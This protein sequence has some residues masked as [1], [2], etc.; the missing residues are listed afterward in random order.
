MR[1]SIKT[2]NLDYPRAKIVISDSKNQNPVGIYPDNGV[3]ADT[4]E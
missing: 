2:L 3:L 1:V 4:R